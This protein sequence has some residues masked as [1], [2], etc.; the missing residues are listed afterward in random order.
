MSEKAIREIKP[1]VI[2]IQYFVWGT[3]AAGFISLFPGFFVFIISN[4]IQGATGRHSF[5]G[6]VFIYG[7]TAYILSFVL[8]MFL[9]Y[10]KTFREPLRTTYTIFENRIEYD[11]GFLNR[12]RRTLVFDQ[13]IDV[14]LAEGLL[15]Q[16]KGAGTITLVTQQLVS[17]GEGKLSNRRIALRNVPK[18]EETYDLI[19]SLAMKNKTA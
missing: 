3:L 15:Q 11:E 14:H 7:A 8:S 1:V 19:R 13:V 9:I 17:S 2:P 18:A 5:D 4:I 12:N 6:P 10:L 16:T